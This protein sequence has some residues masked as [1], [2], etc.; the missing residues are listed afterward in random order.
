MFEALSE[1]VQNVRRYVLVLG[2]EEQNEAIR[3]GARRRHG[4]PGRRGGGGLRRT[5]AGLT[6]G[7]CIQRE[8]RSQGGR[9]RVRDDRTRE[10]LCPGSAVHD[11]ADGGRRLSGRRRDGLPGRDDGRADE[12]LRDAG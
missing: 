1:V 11:R 2:E 6:D 4:G 5:A 9:E 7:R 3:G 8:L 12:R 10:L